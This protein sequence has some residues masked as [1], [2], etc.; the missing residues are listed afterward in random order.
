MHQQYGKQDRVERV[1]VLR[2][3]QLQQLQQEENGVAAVSSK[4]DRAAEQILPEKAPPVGGRQADCVYLN[5][6]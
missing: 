1:L 3:K 2:S 4:V 6:Q 5:S